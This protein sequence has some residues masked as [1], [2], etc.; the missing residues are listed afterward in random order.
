M[1]ASR[2]LARVWTRLRARLH[3][4]GM[5]LAFVIALTAMYSALA[6]RRHLTFHSAGWNLGI[7]EKAIRN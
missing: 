4:Q 7:F 3:G 2:S 6:I 5:P 1:L